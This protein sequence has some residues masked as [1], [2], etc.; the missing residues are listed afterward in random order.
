MIDILVYLFENYHDLATHP[1]PDALARKLSALGFEDDDI[2]QA[3]VWLNALRSSRQPEWSCD[4]RSQRIY[5]AEEYNRL[6]GEC[7]SFVLFLERAGVLSAARREAVLEHAMRLPEHPV[8][9]EMFK[10]IVLMVLWSGEED[11][12]PLIVEELLCEADSEPMH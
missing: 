3:L 9:L 6:G 8:T 5:T 4:A 11:L 12:A 1:K 7:L 10:I 2:S